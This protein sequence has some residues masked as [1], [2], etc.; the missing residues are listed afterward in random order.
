V[1]LLLLHWLLL[2]QENHLSEKTDDLVATTKAFALLVVTVGSVVG[3]MLIIFNG[4][5]LYAEYLDKMVGVLMV[6]AGIAGAGEQ[7]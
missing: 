3:I 4:S 7:V 6:V 2:K 1:L 5:P